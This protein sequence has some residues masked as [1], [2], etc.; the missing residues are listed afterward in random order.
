MNGLNHFIK[1]AGLTGYA[2][3]KGVPAPKL[4]VFVTGLMLLA[5]GLGVIFLY[6]IQIALWFIIIFLLVVSL[7][8]HNFWAV[9]DPQTKMMEMTNFTKNFALMGAAL[10]LLTLLSL[11]SSY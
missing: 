1:S 7:K 3:S 8:M 4:A 2:Q 6:Y 11:P 5:G 10:I 9:T